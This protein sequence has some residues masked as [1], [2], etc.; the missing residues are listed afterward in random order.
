[1]YITVYIKKNKRKFKIS[2]MTEIHK[3]VKCKDDWVAE[4]YAEVD[5]ETGD[6]Y[7]EQ[8]IMSNPKFYGVINEKV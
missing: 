5:N 7:S 3:F 4:I 2:M 1:M 8:I 6:V